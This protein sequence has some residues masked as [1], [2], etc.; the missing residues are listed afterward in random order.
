M[1][2][3]IHIET[4]PHTRMVSYKIEQW[5]NLLR[6]TAITTT[7]YFITEEEKV[8]KRKKSQWTEY[9]EQGTL[10]LMPLLT[11]FP[12]YRT[13]VLV[14]ISNQSIGVLVKFYCGFSKQYHIFELPSWSTT[15]KLLK[16]VEFLMYAVVQNL[17]IKHFHSNASLFQITL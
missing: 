15:F 16:S 8:C 9:S 11:N 2:F 14:S 1:A 6:K 4:N 10:V 13:K 3:V 17:K 7:F 12:W 5:S